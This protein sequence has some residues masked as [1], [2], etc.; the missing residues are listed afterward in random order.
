MKPC[1]GGWCH[2]REKCAH[3]HSLYRASP[4]ERLCPP[5]HEQPVYWLVHKPLKE[6]A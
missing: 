3:F 5:K 4:S 6:A 2:Q 1:M